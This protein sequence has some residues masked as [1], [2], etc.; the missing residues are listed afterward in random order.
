MSV[1]RT[2]SRW[3][4]AIAAS[5]L[6]VL[7]ACG[8]GSGGSSNENTGG[9][10]LTVWFP[11]NS[12]PEI[13]LVTKT[14]VP[15]FEAANNATV[16]VTYVPWDQISPKLNAGFAGNSAPDVF[17]HGPAAAA[18]FVESDRIEPLDDYLAKL[19]EADRTDLASA[20]AGGKVNGKQYMV[21]L[22]V[23]GTL[24]G[25]RKDLFQS[26]GVTPPTTWAESLAAAQKLTTRAGGKVERA[27]LLL[28][29]SKIQRVQAFQGL[30]G[31]EGGALLTADEKKAAWHSPEGVR[32]LEFY[33]S[34]F[35]GDNAVGNQLGANFAGQPPAQH[36]L[37]TGH[38]AMAMANSQQ[39]V[40]IVKA[41]PDLADKIGVLA[42]LKGTST[43]QMFGGAGP[44]LFLN[45]DSKNKD[46]AWKFMEFMLSKQ[47]SEQY[48]ETIGN[49]P[50]RA[51][52]ADSTYVSANP[53]LKVFLK[54][55]PEYVG[56]PNVPAWVQVR[57]V[58]DK[59]LEQALNG[60]TSAKQALDAA[61]AEADPLL[62]K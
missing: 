11:G 57:D 4:V 43:A 5:C 22:S 31:S 7:A 36:P 16:E 30:L 44:G 49:V 27:G 21:P 17:G 58:L 3:A 40:Q 38:A 10:K 6:V 20:L 45:S 33:T 51:S 52:S 24:I 19:A 29:S 28:Q 9:G 32:A 13:E 1:R 62:A 46:L 15:E 8:T 12:A 59:H 61:A 39:L 53:L 34:L 18:G 54:A 37:A 23:Q 47:V 48:A 42:P 26:A 2:R 60:K 14:L 35:Q 25:Y 50:A 41:V 56:S 55:G